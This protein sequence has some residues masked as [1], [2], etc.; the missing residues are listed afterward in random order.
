MHSATEKAR[1]TPGATGL[2]G[3]FNGKRQWRFL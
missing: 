3:V 2:H 1:A